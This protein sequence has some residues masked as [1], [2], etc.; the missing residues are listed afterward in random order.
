MKLRLDCV[1]IADFKRIKELEIDLSPVTALIGGNTCGKSSALQAAQLGVSVLQAAHRRIKKS[2]EHEFFKSV[3]HD[4]VLFRPT[5]NLLDLRHGETA[6]QNLGYSITYE[7][8]DLDADTVKSVAVEIKRGKNANIATTIDGDNEV[9]GFLADGDKP[10]S[11]LTPGLS[12]LSLREEWRTRGAM[13]A[14]VMHGDANLYLRTILDHLFTRDLNDAAKDRWNARQDILA[15]P[16]GGW[17]TFC[18]LLNRCYPGASV[19]VDH[20]PRRQRYVAVFIEYGGARMT[21]DMASTGMLQVIQILAYACFYAPPL[22][23]LDEP[24]AHLHAD[25]QARLYEALRGVAEETH[26]RILF[27]SHSP[28]LIQR[29]MYDTDAALVWMNEGGRVPV[30][31]T[32]RPAIPILMALGALTSGADVFDPNRNIIILTEDKLTNPLLKIAAASGSGDNAACLSYNGCGNLQGA[33]L[34]ARIIV[35]MRDDARVFIHRDRDFRTDA[36]VGFEQAVFEAYCR[37]E[38][39]DRVTE[40]FTPLNDVEH[41][42]TQ[43]EHLKAVFAGRV[44]EAEIDAILTETI[45]RLRDEMVQA[46]RVARS[47]I[48]NSL[49]D[50]DRMRR[51]DEWQS[52]GMPDAAPPTGDFI[53]ADGLH[54]VA[55]ENCHGKT[56]MR[57]L[58]SAIHNRIGGNTKD[59]EAAIYQSAPTVSVPA[60]TNAFAQAV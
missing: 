29:M 57:A 22:L 40:L 37:N 12:G 1:K 7:C 15:L 52:E 9:A 23:L 55:F 42:F 14:A 8:T 30:D 32:H 45:A 31:D 54:P 58:K 2:G 33:R 41:L 48:N 38:K 56:L 26:T 46:A 44:A 43:P 28:Q 24:D 17:K 25:S 35:D 53:P 11:I 50:S 21:L 16:E 10:F 34:L 20:D 36:E 59:I 5:E 49:Y 6:T 13:D 18:S 27:A 51:K 4:A 39:I 3:S 19:V 60:W 47:K